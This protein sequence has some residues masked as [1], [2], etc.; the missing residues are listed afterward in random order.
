[1]QSDTAVVGQM[2]RFW[3]SMAADPALGSNNGVSLNL[4]GALHL[5]S[6]WCRRAKD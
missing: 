2:I 3:E 1:M 4:G 5:W 6:H